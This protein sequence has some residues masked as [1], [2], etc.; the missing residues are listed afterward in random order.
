MT[1]AMAGTSSC[2]EAVAEPLRH[3]SRW[4][5]RIHDAGMCKVKDGNFAHMEPS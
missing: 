1:V 4:K 3:L 5:D 2:A